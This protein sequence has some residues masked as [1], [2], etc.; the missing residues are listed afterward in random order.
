MIA[1]SIAPLFKSEN[2]KAVVC[3]A[4]RNGSRARSFLVPGVMRCQSGDFSAAGV[5]AVVCLVVFNTC[6]IH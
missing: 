3:C 2:P 1:V 4:Q 6:Q 5:G